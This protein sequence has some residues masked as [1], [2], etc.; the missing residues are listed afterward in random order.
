MPYSPAVI[1]EAVDADVVERLLDF[2]SGVFFDSEDLADN[3]PAALRTLDEVI[4]GHLAGVARTF[5]GDLDY[6]RGLCKER[7][8]SAPADIRC[9]GLLERLDFEM[10]GKPYRALVK[11]SSQGAEVFVDAD[12]FGSRYFALKLPRCS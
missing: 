2:N 10:L 3:L 1:H 6:L 9:G 4:I 7:A 11:L 8:A 5:G 12:R